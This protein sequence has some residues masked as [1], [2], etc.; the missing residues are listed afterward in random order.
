M[1]LTSRTPFPGHAALLP[2]CGALLF[3]AAG[4]VDVRW[5]PRA[6]IRWRVSQTLGDLSYSVYLWHWP[7]IIFWPY[8]VGSRL[9]LWGKLVILVATL[10][11]AWLSKVLVE[12]R[13]RV[14]SGSHPRP[15]V[16]PAQLAVPKPAQRDQPT[17]RTL[18]GRSPLR[19]LLRPGIVHRLDKDTS[20]VIES[21]SQLRVAREG[22]V[23]ARSAALCQL[24]DLIVTA[25]A[26]LRE[27]LTSRTLIGR[28]RHCARL[29]PDAGRLAELLHAA[30]FALRSLALR[31]VAFDNEI[32]QLD[33]VLKELVH[34]AAPRPDF[35]SS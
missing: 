2:V 9:T 19:G 12:D 22:A 15:A 34:Q 20:G 18:D 1:L 7:L 23:K 13:Y 33:Q 21:I 31:I 10:V 6:L 28:A 4:T 29:R 14:H 35:R 30:K 17:D 25:S 27:S 32:S 3:I 16:Q 8:V 11:L 24:G 5:S 26:E